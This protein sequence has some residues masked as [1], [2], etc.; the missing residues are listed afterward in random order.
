MQI[1][2]S[3]VV[4]KWSKFLHETP[5]P[6]RQKYIY[7]FSRGLGVLAFL[8]SSLGVI[9][10]LFAP[11]EGGLQSIIS[12]F[13]LG[14]FCVSSHVLATNR[15]N[16]SAFIFYLAM[17]ATMSFS[18][19]QSA[20]F[21]Y[22]LSFA[23]SCVVA[24][25]IF[26]R[27]VAVF[28]LVLYAV[29]SFLYADIFGWGITTPIGQVTTLDPATL[30]LWWLAIALVLWLV[31]I[32]YSDFIKYNLQLKYNK[33]MLSWAQQ[34]G[35][36]GNYVYDL[37]TRK[38][39]WSDQLFRINGLEPGQIIPSLKTGLTYV[40]PDDRE[41]LVKTN[42]RAV[43]EGQAECETRTI[44]HTGELRYLL[45]KISL[46]RDINGKPVSLLGTVL[47]VTER[48][49]A[50]E[51]L[52]RQ[53]ARSQAVAELSQLLANVSH[54]YSIVLETIVERMSQLFGDIC[55]I[56][57]LTPEKERLEYVAVYHADPEIREIVREVLSSRVPQTSSEG[58]A[59]QVLRTG[60]PIIS[61]A[62][63]PDLPILIFSSDS[64]QPKNE[65]KVYSRIM[66]PLYASNKPIGVM[67]LARL[68]PGQPYS[69]DE[70]DFMEDLAN[71]AALA[72]TNSRLYNSL[73]QELAERR[74]TEEALR[75]SEERFRSLSEAAMEG[76]IISNDA[77]IQDAN[78]QTG[79]MLNCSSSELIDA[80]LV[81]FIAPGETQ[82]VLDRL[83]CGNAMPFQFEAR[84]KG[85]AI[86]PVEARV[87]SLPYKG[88][89]VQV[90]VLHDITERKRAE[91]ERETLIA[92]LEG[93]NAELERFTYTVSH[94][95]KSPL[96]TILGFLGYLEKDA[97]SGNTTRLK[98]DITRIS[99]ATTKMQ[100]L[101]DELLELS[102]IG[103]LVNPPQPLKF[104]GLVREA[105][106]LVEGQLTAR[107]VKVQIAEG[108]PLVNGDKVRLI[109]VLQNLLDN[110]VKFMG[111]E[112][113]PLI[114]I[115][116]KDRG[117]EGWAT[118]YVKDNGIGIEALYYDKVFGLFDKL[119]PHSEGTGIGLALAKRIIEVHGGRIWVESE[120][121]NKGATFYFSLPT[122]KV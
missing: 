109:E 80:P 92:E 11:W 33:D 16:S 68:Q 54:D 27:L 48:R 105:L 106:F 12:F 73:E 29:Q 50:E 111:E 47:N 66:L 56:Q 14:L 82:K 49:K 40:H 35:D 83:T 7:N 122:I 62:T 61:E 93:K 115:G 39:T 42:S 59:A 98:I 86:F 17:I 108:L 81:N 114:S 119:D 43:T 3:L 110:A 65:V 101:L 1:L 85:G 117:P 121:K 19:W 75:E 72:I 8:V 76:I 69:L 63:S 100:R 21:I 71:R 38:V 10:Y 41:I 104:E 116:L 46:V 13:I 25:L 45:T 60:K 94:D 9:W 24:L 97:L 70:L 103:R 88:K 78:T 67:G 89:P 36:I 51:Q 64:R 31:T 2:T 96:I 37:S 23:L 107:G 84:R 120:G 90:M 44:T 99:D 95:L 77:Q 6:F 18:F 15:E 91:V 34:V 22:Y 5:P 53:V 102:R 118:F 20:Y 79:E 57:L 112:S 32:I 55:A 74:R 30:C 26:G 28:T 113:A 52:Q 58:V 87:R 4:K